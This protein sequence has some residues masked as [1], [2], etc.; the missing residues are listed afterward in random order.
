MK[1]GL[2]A[3]EKALHF[4]DAVSHAEH[5]RRLAPPYRRGACRATRQLDV[6]SWH[7][8]YLQSGTFD[9]VPCSR[10]SATCCA[11]PSRGFPTHPPDRPCGWGTESPVPLE[12]LADYE[13]RVNRVLR[14]HDPVIASTTVRELDATLAAEVLAH[15]PDDH[16]RRDPRKPVVQ[17]TVFSLCKPRDAADML[18]ERYVAALL[19]GNRRTALDVVW[20]DGFRVA[21]TC[22][23]ST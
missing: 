11:P 6:R 17:T 8:T 9:A 2:E 23:V 21:S 16:R 1:E 18:R 14:T 22:R 3:G 15:I 20:E 10:S 19:V 13:M 7:E 4:V 5:F 12:A